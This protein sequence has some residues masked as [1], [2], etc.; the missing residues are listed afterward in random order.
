VLIGHPVRGQFKLVDT[1]KLAQTARDAYRF[2]LTVPAGQAA[3]ET[4]TEERDVGS[5]VQ[6][7]N[8]PHKQI[9]VVGY[10]CVEPSAVSRIVM[11]VGRATRAGETHG[12][13]QQT[14]S[15]D[16]L[17]TPLSGAALGRDDRRRFLFSFC[18]RQPPRDCSH[19]T[20]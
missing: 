17:A 10:Y 1:T 20:C 4:V 15:L 8:S 9:R 18:A 6:L 14:E 7:T 5:A 12:E 16:Y 3:K 11:A 2:E 19:P 13:R